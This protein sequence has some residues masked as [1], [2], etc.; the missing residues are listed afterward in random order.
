LTDQKKLNLDKNIVLQF[1]TLEAEKDMMS[2]TIRTEREIS[3]Y[4]VETS[5][6]LQKLKHIKELIVKIQR[7]TIKILDE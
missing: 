3:T 1:D 2:P 6:N 4:G 5:I 7:E